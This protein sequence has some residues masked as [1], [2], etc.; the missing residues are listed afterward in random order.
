M[1]GRLSMVFLTLGANNISVK[2]STDQGKNH[3]DTQTIFF[4]NDSE[5][6]NYN[7]KNSTRN[8]CKCL[9]PLYSR[10]SF[11]ITCYLYTTFVMP[12]SRLKL[13]IRGIKIYYEE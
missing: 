9:S 11:D 3:F 1:I 2:A 12:K 10:G 4:S 13:K 8:S 6:F 5:K 7:L